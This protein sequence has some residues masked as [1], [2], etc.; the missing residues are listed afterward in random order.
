MWL[1]VTSFGT[2][3]SPRR[4]RAADEMKPKQKQDREVHNIFVHTP[5]HLEPRNV[6]K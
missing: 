1:A 3:A 4:R 2:I 6:F 5:I